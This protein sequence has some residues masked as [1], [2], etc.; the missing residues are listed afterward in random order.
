MAG[1]IPTLMQYRYNRMI[2]DE[3]LRKDAEEEAKKKETVYRPM[4]AQEFQQALQTNLR[5]PK[6]STKKKE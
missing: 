2:V 6:V 3:R 5:M 1:I 4:T